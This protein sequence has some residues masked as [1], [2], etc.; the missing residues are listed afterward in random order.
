MICDPCPGPRLG[1]GAQKAKAGGKESES[2]PDPLQLW[3]CHPG[4]QG[5]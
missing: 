2:L 5:L 4:N 1:G 3:L